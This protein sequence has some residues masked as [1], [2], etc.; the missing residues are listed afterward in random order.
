MSRL[1]VCRR[2]A[3]AAFGLWTAAAAGAPNQ[4]LDEVRG[5]LKTLKS[6]LR[7]T[8]ESRAEAAGR[9]RD[10]ER[11]IA[12]ANRK[13]RD[14]GRQRDALSHQ[15]DAIAAEIQTTRTEIGRQQDEIARMLH[16]QYVHGRSEP[17]RVAFSREDPNATARRLHYLTYVSRARADVVTALRTNL[18]SLD[19]L[20]Q[21]T[22]AKQSELE[23]VEKEHRTQ[24]EALEREKASRREVLAS[25]S[26]EL[27][28][29]RKEYATLKK[30]EERLTRLVEKLARASAKPLRNKGAG[31]DRT[32]S[33]RG[34]PD[35]AAPSGSFRSL[36]GRLRLPVA[37]ELISRFGSPRGD[38]GFSRKGVFLRAASGQEV[39][40]IAQGRVVFAEFLRG[41]GN[42]LIVDHGDG[43]M[44]LY[45]N[46]DTMLK[47]PGDAVR[48]GDVIASVGASGGQE[49]SGLY[50]ELRHQG[51]PFDP[52]PWAPPR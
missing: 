47:R 41:F 11:A 4:D 10:S 18:A 40:A 32:V 50:F 35:E 6:E 1:A 21:S 28:T 43:Y 44:S 16:T 48:P 33:N 27:A 14:L 17:L 30:D 37:G 25:V 8:E 38:N 24:R 5:R 29:K 12:D 36:K 22:A 19:T 15:L 45:G 2:V 34:V 51:R 52:L 26:A 23:A 13:L 39:K 7:D 42:L 20:T 49:E 31:K 46:N 3:I 9:L